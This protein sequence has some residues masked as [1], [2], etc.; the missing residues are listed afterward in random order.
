[1]IF[2]SVFGPMLWTCSEA[3]VLYHAIMIDGTLERSR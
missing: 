1:M 3:V 2:Q